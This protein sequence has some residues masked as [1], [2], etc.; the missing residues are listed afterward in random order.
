MSYIYI[1]VREQKVRDQIDQLPDEQ[2]TLGKYVEMGELQEIPK[3]NAQA[4]QSV[5]GHSTVI[6]AISRQDSNN[7]KC[8]RCSKNHPKDQCKVRGPV[9]YNCGKGGI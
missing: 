8:K 6:N 9:C 5:N 3:A 4:F 7:L 1:G 2:H